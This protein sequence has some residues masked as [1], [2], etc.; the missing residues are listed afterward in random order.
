[1]KFIRV[2]QRFSIYMFLFSLNF[3]TMNLFNLGIEYL[4]SKITI[5]LL[6]LFSLFSLRQLFTFKYYSRY[7]LPLGGYFLFLTAISIYYINSSSAVFFDFPFFLNILILLV[8]C[9]YSRIYPN[10]L[11]KG[12]LAL[13]ISSFVLSLLYLLGIG[14]SSNLEGRFSIFNM[15][16]NYFGFNLCISI[17]VLFFIVFKNRLNLKK[18]RYLLLLMLPS[19]LFVMFE[20]GSRVAFISFVL[21]LF[22]IIYYNKSMSRVKKII[23]LFIGVVCFILIWFL[24]IKNTMVGG[25]IFSTINEGDLSSRDLIWAGVFEIIVN[26]YIIGV[27]QTGYA[28]KMT[29]LFGGFG[30]PH[31][32]LLEV[33]CYTG[34][35]GLTIFLIFF[36]RIAN[37]AVRQNKY[38]KEILPLLLLIP[39]TGLILSGQIFDAKVVWVLFA[40]IA[41]KSPININSLKQKTKNIK[42]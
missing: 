12:L 33:V 19:L 20:T 4:A 18:L 3:E 9:N 28:G 30:S 11:L 29:N 21:G 34:L 31:N 6:I 41:S 13:T 15:N 7:F 17:F 36:F 2:A 38:E 42:T 27:G 16:E 10:I 25:R 35:I 14:V 39:I 32:V 22:A 26:N 8:L 5:S 1:M 23:L 24:F 37:N 40:Y